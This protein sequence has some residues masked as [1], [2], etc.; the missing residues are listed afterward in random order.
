MVYG[1]PAV[2]IEGSMLMQFVV[3][4]TIHLLQMF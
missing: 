1:Q 2:C 3:W 4:H